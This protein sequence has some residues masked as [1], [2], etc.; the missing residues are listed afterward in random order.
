MKKLSILCL[1][2]FF[3][4]F[5]TAQTLVPYLLKNGKYLYV[6]SATMKPLIEKEYFNAFP[7]TGGRAFV[8]QE[9]RKPLAL[10]DK[11]GKELTG[12]IYRNHS[13]FR[14]GWAPVSTNSGKGMIIDTTGKVIFDM[15]NYTSQFNEGMASFKI[16]EIDKSSADYKYLDKYGF[17]DKSGK[18]VI[19]AQYDYAYPFHEGLARVKL[20][21]KYGFIDKQG[22]VVVQIKYDEAE[23]FSNGVA[24]V[25]L[26]KKKGY[27]DLTGKEVVS[28]QYDHA[29]KAVTDLL[30]V[31]N[32]DTGSYNYKFGFIDKTGKIVIPLKYKMVSDF[33]NGN[34]IVQEVNKL[35]LINKKGQKL[36]ALDR[37]DSWYEFSEGFSFGVI[38]KGLPDAGKLILINSKG[39]EVST[40]KF[41]ALKKNFVNG[42]AMVW[43]GK[44][45]GFIDTT[46]KLVTPY[47]Y[48]ECFDGFDEGF[49][50]VQ[51]R[52]D[53]FYIDKAGREYREK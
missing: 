31:G 32:N 8:Q 12:F 21:K 37:F 28:L 5:G 22:K 42:M 11:T 25:T 19:P 3:Y 49:A 6:D 9:Y 48:D 34:A 2:S 26:N 47:L 45:I 33:S 17:T 27:V 51:Q 40:V 46:G 4:L 7:F 13:L 52:F 30:R 23:N 18:A 53:W 36:A 39:K 14:D 20:N 15:Q 50:S 16:L 29:D 43:S 1:Y 38:R 10:I 24:V 35:F 41:E 44:K